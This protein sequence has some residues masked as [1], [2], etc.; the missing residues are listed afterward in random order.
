MGILTGGSVYHVHTCL[1][2]D[3]RGIRQRE[4]KLTGSCRSGHPQTRKH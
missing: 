1:D 3:I 2:V 4:Q